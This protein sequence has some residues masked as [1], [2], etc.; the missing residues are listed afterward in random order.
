[1]R[2]CSTGATASSWSPLADHLRIGRAGSGNAW[3][4]RMNRTMTVGGGCAGCGN[5]W[6]VRVNRTMTVGGGDGRG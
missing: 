1:M 6:A 2:A 5:A 3:V 4:V